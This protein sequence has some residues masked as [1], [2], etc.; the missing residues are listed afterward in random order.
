MYHASRE[1]FLYLR[2]FYRGE[3]HPDDRA[4]V[5]HGGADKAS[6]RAAEP[7]GPDFMLQLREYTE[8]FR[9]KGLAP[10]MTHNHLGS[11]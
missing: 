8:G 9:L 4:S 6:G 7:P 10:G 5:P 1:S 11:K 2:D 3:I